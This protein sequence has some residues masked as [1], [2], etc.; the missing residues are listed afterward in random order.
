[1]NGTGQQVGFGA[2]EQVAAVQPCPGGHA[3]TQAGG[4]GSAGRASDNTGDKA[5]RTA[6]GRSL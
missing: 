5:G 6:W 2:D 4:L 3:L 1:V